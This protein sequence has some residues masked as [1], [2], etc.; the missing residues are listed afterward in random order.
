MVVTVPNLVIVTKGGASMFGFSTCFSKVLTTNFS[1]DLPLS[2]FD[3]LND[4]GLEGGGDLLRMGDLVL[5]N[6]GDFGGSGER[7]TAWMGDAFRL[8]VGD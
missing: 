3:L 7:E 1:G 5:D 8:G 2:S 6:G 4:L